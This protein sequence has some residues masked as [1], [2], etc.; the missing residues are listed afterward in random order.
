MKKPINGGKQ[1]H[2][3]RR[4]EAFDQIGRRIQRRLVG[5]RRRTDIE[6]YLLHLRVVVSD[7][8]HRASVG[9]ALIA[10]QIAA[11][12]GVEQM[13]E[14]RREWSESI[15]LKAQVQRIGET[16]NADLP[17]QKIR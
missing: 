4:L 5:L 6:P 10:M 13:P 9:E 8:V 3:E 2:P 11:V 14:L 15:S 17:L 12:E 1:L 16:S 7:H